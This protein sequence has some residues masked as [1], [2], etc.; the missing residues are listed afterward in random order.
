VA[1]ALPGRDRLPVGPT[2][3]FVV[4]LHQLYDAAG[5]P[6][7][8][9]ISRAIFKSVGE[10]IESV[11]HETVSSVLRGATV[12]TWGKVQAIVTVLARASRG[13]PD[14]DQIL[15]D[16]QTLWIEVRRSGEVQPAR[17]DAVPPPAMTIPTGRPRSA[18]LADPPI[19]ATEDRIIGTLPERNTHFTGR[20][21]L[22][23]TMADQH[24]DHPH[25]PL[26]L[27]G[28]GG[29]GKTQL[30]LEY[31]HRY[32]GT[33]SVVWW[34]PAERVEQARTSLVSLAERL[35]LPLRQSAEQTVSG[36]LGRLESQQIRYLL[37]FDGA[38]GEDVR[39]LIPA[40]G[41][42][43]I[44][45]SRDPTWAHDSAN[46]GLEVPDF[47]L[48][49]AIQFLRKRDAAMTGEQAAGVT[50]QLGLLPL[51]LE[52][53]AALRLATGLTWDDL[54]SHMNGPAPGLFSAAAE[55][56]HYPHTVSASLK[57]ALDQLRG[58]NPVAL[59]VFELF[60]WFGA[61]PVSLPLLRRGGAGEL[62]PGL[63]RTL[64]NPIHLNRA[65]VDINRYGLGR[66][67]IGE[68]RIEVQPLMR[69]ALRDLLSDE[70][71]GR[72]L[73]N[74][75][76]ILTIAGKG[77]PDELNHWDM[78]RAVAPHVL[79]A[80]MI[81]SR[82]AQTAEAVHNQI[83]YR[84]LIG[85]FEDARQLG[86]AAVTAWRSPD[87]LGPDHELVLLASRQ[88]ANALRSLGRYEQAREITADAM[89][90]MRDNPEFG[91][92]HRYALEMARSHAADLRI[93]GEY[94]DA[95]DLDRASYERF[96]RKEGATHDGTVTSRHN[97]AV[98]LRLLGD[99]G[100]AEVI[101]R[102]EVAFQLQRRGED[103]RK[104]LLSR[105]ALAEDLY[106]LGRFTDVRVMR[107][108]LENGQRTLPR[109][110]HAVLLAR[111]VVALALRRLG[112]TGGASDLLRET[113]YECVESWGADH[114]FT[115]AATMSYANALLARNRTGEAYALAVDAVNA[116][117]HAFG[118]NNPLTVAAQ[119]NLAV[120]FRARG[121]RHQARRAD[122]AALQSLGRLVGDRHPF[123][124]VAM[125]N[126]ASDMAHD[127]DRVGAYTMSRR[128]WRTALEV[129]GP[130]HFE[131]LAAA[132]NLTLDQATQQAEDAG[133]PLDEVLAGLRRS[134][135]PD[136]PVVANVAGGMRVECDIEPPST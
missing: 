39:S 77:W 31:V 118:N 65:I 40:I 3:D 6:A 69:L 131:T 66:L 57:L 20:E 38:E 10:E 121:E 59:Q 114:E 14:L 89:V 56:T 88:W 102:E 104:T 29:A 37:V 112:D 60:A 136:H 34:V 127:G 28:L 33:Y 41:G 119:V 105:S 72:A 100:A 84:Y 86:E 111:R 93:A 70:A 117:E 48:A 55:P 135:G 122:D 1:I 96:L 134:I 115:L 126:L 18:E 32:L 54:V 13:E 11:S 79:P 124:I 4:A 78:H 108:D 17:R 12:P 2:R 74:V 52:Q 61:D 9:Q 22:L 128:A 44:V 120:I 27:Y 83:R 81:E 129:R 53:V 133:P 132:A 68:Q 103:D 97:L 107:P 26:V 92:D 8:R 43:V 64:S 125:I 24:R 16:I 85:D 76:N 30:A 106:G 87:V 47:N 99:F 67:H 35:G 75:Q 110:D 109:G 46:V 36:V 49:E 130:Q 5:Q 90:R 50:R 58:A 15:D 21:L 80:L 63:K 73:K 95:L 7:S 94:G 19:V 51:A 62:S 25:A 82:D 101:D 123:T 42:N 91:D 98:C 45:T 116:Y 113:Y 23:D 71:R